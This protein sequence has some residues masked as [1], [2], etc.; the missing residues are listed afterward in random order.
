M[1]KMLSSGGQGSTMLWPSV[2]LASLWVPNLECGQDCLLKQSQ[3]PAWTV[4]GAVLP[5]KHAFSQQPEGDGHTVPWSPLRSTV[6]SSGQ[7]RPGAGEGVLQEGQLGASGAFAPF[8]WPPVSQPEPSP[9]NIWTGSDSQHCICS[10]WCL[11]TAHKMPQMADLQPC[12]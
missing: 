7:G 11:H 8:R 10:R 9:A 2:A 1:C 3:P 6:A 12:M 5:G 4:P